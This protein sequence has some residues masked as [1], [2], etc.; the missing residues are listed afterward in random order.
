MRWLEKYLDFFYSNG[1]MCDKSH[2]LIGVHAYEHVYDELLKYE[3]NL[4]G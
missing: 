3:D 2:Y 1:V 4:I